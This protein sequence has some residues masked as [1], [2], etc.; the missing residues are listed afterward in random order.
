MSDDLLDV[1]NN[2]RRMHSEFPN[3]G[4]TCNWM[5]FMLNCDSGDLDERDAGLTINVT[6]KRRA[7]NLKTHKLG[8][9]E[10]YQVTL[11]DTPSRFMDNNLWIRNDNSGEVK[12]VADF[13]CPQSATT[14]WLN[15]LVRVLVRWGSD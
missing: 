10:Y 14:A 3:M 6:I 5:G 4:A 2:M 11:E 13:K 15:E 8:K 9:G 1:L 12:M 7:G